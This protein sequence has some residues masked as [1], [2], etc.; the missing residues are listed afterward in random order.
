[1]D[2]KNLP[3]GK[4]KLRIKNPQFFLC[5]AARVNLLYCARTSRRWHPCRGRVPLFQTYMRFFSRTLVN[6]A[7]FRGFL[8]LVYGQQDPIKR[9]LFRGPRS[10]H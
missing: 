1:M 3:N 8:K 7:A 4:L 5:A 2:W 9:S 6:M 10:R